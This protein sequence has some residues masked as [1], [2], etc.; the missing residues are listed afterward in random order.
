MTKKSKF[1]NSAKLAIA[2]VVLAG[3]LSSC[4]MMNG[5][6][7]CMSKGD[8]AKEEKTNCSSSMK[9]EKANCSSSE[10]ESKSSCSSSMKEE[11]AS[12]SSSKKKK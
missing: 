11:K 7:N 9:D 8:Q 2:G 6:H 5:K 10:K 4:G 3:G 1:L 12:C